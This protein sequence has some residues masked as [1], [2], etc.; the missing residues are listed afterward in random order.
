MSLALQITKFPVRVQSLARDLAQ[1]S[2]TPKL[3]VEALLGDDM[4]QNWRIRTH[5]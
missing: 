1:T 4:I 5:E 2:F 3:S